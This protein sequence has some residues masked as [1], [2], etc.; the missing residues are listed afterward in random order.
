MTATGRFYI[1]IFLA[2][3]MILLIPFNCSEDVTAPGNHPPI[4][5]SLV[6]DPDKINPGAEIIM[7]AFVRDLEGDSIRYHWSSWPKATWMS[8]SMAPVCTMAVNQVLEGGMQ[9][10][11]ALDA[12]DGRLTSSDSLWII[13]TEGQ[14]VY[15]HVFFE[16]TRIPI[17]GTEVFIRRLI[18]TTGYLGDYRLKH[19]PE[20]TRV[21]EAAKDNCGAYSEEI[22]VTDSVEYD[23][24]MTC[25]GLTHTL[26]GNVST[27]DDI[28]LSHVKVTILN[29]DSTATSITTITDAL[30]AF[31]LA[32][33]P[34]GPRLIGIE[35]TGNPDHQILSD[36][37]N[38]Y[39]TADTAVD[40]RGR[41][42][43]PI[44]LSRGINSPMDWLFIDA[45]P[46]TSWLIDETD[47]CYSYNSCE[48]GGIGRLTLAEPIHIPD[49]VGAISYLLK[50]EMHE[51]VLTAFYLIDG[52]PINSENLSSFTGDVVIDRQVDILGM[53]PSG[54]EFSIE[55][56]SWSNSNNIC[57]TICL[58]EFSISF[59]R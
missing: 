27:V 59:Y 9:L 37:F 57:G 24:F 6:S 1:S 7:T 34:Q 55:F 28:L 8:D 4:I 36:T 14:L 16:N 30:G 58:K 20:G 45:P 18:D 44:F 11:I 29:D 56:W 42:R 39:I 12:S 48:I 3:G 46:F 17:P 49:S 54:H 26:T 33:V 2:L 13:L 52:E 43:R 47:S 19:V 32:G 35:D 31:S 23:I 21:I 53:D 40:L 50:A 5:D 25:P 15:G 51:I 10:M 38:V 41:I 22:S